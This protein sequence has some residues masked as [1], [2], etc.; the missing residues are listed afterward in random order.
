M[1]CFYQVCPHG[2]FQVLVI[3]RKGESILWYNERDT[4]AHFGCH[5]TGRFSLSSSAML[6][7]S[8]ATHPPKVPTTWI[9]FVH[10]LSAHAISSKLLITWVVRMYWIYW[11]RPWVLRALG[12]G[13]P[14]H[15]SY[16]LLLVIH[17]SPSSKEPLV[18]Q[19]SVTNDNSQ[20]KHVCYI[21]WMLLLNCHTLMVCTCAE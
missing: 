7:T 8:L 2:F 11:P 10:A 15:H 5:S 18:C 20:C 9:Q 12:L 16:Q 21:R 14:I 6:A 17:S 19:C 1:P 4:F 13:P 3:S